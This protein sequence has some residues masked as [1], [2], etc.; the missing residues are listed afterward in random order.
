MVAEVSCKNG[1]RFIFDAHEYAPLD[2]EDNFIWRMFYPLMIRYFLKKYST[3]VNGF[4][5]VSPKIGERYGKEYDVQP[6]II[7]NAP[8]ID[9]IPQVK[10]V[11][12]KVRMILHGGA[13]KQRKLEKMI[14]TLALCNANYT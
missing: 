1:A 9:H 2:W 13:I 8:K 7:L 14:E 6:V 10:P 12:E 11:G 4:I 3:T 5:T